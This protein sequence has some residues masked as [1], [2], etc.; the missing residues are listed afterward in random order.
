M[1]ISN[2]IIDNSPLMDFDIY[3]Y[4]FERCV[5]IKVFQ[6]IENKLEMEWSR[7]KWGNILR[8]IISGEE[9]L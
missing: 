8:R 1:K 3:T 9:E 2:Y 5:T 7:P 4:L 6:F